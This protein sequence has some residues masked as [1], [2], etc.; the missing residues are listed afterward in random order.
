MKTFTYFSTTT[1]MGFNSF[2]TL[3][4]ILCKPFLTFTASTCMLTAPRSRIR[5][6]ATSPFSFFYNKKY[7]RRS[8]TI[9]FSTL[10]L[11]I[12]SL[13]S[14]TM[15]MNSESND[16]NPL[17]DHVHAALYGPPPGS[18]G[19]L[20]SNSTDKYMS[21]GPSFPSST[22]AG[23]SSFAAAAGPDP[24]AWMNDAAKAKNP[25]PKPP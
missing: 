9:S 8:S 17:T 4:T 15:T 19:A 3:N 22:T 7:Q 2:T 18:S 14:L 10:L 24:H 16:P 25:F 20:L 13:L 21:S 12:F 6:H 5:S 23:S 1:I 11:R